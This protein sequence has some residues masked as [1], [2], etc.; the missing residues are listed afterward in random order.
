MTI[1][2]YS[3]PTELAVPGGYVSG[4][5]LGPVLGPILAACVTSPLTTSN[6]EIAGNALTGHMVASIPTLTKAIGEKWSTQ[7]SSQSNTTIETKAEAVIARQAHEQP[8]E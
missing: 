4:F 3:K 2:M 1:I 7:T 8:G 5:F 6:I